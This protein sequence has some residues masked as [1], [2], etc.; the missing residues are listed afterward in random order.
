MV[1]CISYSIYLCV[2]LRSNFLYTITGRMSFF[3]I[4]YKRK[5]NPFKFNVNNVGHLGFEFPAR[6]YT[7]TVN[8]IL[9]C[10]CHT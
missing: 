3:W 10:A 8:N 2:L 5:K 1:T 9:G 4:V 6:F 7:N